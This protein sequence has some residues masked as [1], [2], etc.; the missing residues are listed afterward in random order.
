M[1]PWKEKANRLIY[2]VCRDSYVKAQI[3]RLT[4]KRYKNHVPYT[5]PELAVDLI[6]CLNTND[7]ASAK[8]IFLS[9]DRTNARL[10]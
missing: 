3:S 10:C 8:A 4:G 1:E 7:E 2:N 6:A 9:Y 5:V